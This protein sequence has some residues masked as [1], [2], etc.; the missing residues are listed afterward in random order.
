VAQKYGAS[1]EEIDKITHE[2]ALRW[3]RFDPFSTRPMEQC[4]VRAL[5]AEVAGHDVSVRSMDAGRREK[6]QVSLG[7]LAGRATA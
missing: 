5:R 4:T 3:Y 2:N 6:S 1:R 7:E